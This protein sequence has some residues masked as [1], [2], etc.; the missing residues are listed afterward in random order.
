MSTKENVNPA[1]DALL[2]RNNSPY[3]TNPVSERVVEMVGNYMEFL[4]D[5]VEGWLSEIAMYVRK[6]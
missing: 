6:G 2:T 3:T 1:Q 5:N 4:L